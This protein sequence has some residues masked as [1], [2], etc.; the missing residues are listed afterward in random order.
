MTSSVTAAGKK[1]QGDIRSHTYYGR[2]F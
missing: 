1:Y 2:L